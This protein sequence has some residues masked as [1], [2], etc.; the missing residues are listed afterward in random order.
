[1]RRRRAQ[2]GRARRASVRKLASARLRA[3]HR[4]SLN[5]AHPSAQRGSACGSSS[6]RHPASVRAPARTPSFAGALAKTRPARTHKSATS[7]AGP[8]ARR[9]VA[10]ATF[11]PFSPLNFRALQRAPAAQAAQAPVLNSC[12]GG[13]CVCVCVGGGGA[14]EKPRGRRTSGAQRTVVVLLLLSP[15]A[16]ICPAAASHPALVLPGRLVTLLQ[17]QQVLDRALHVLVVGLVQAR[18]HRALDVG[19]HAD[20]R[21]HA[22]HG[23]GA[24]AA[25]AAA[26]R[27]VSRS[28]VPGRPR[29]NAPCSRCCGPQLRRPFSP[30][31]PR[32]PPRSPSPPR[33]LFSSPAP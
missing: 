10:A 7:T 5:P 32:A 16:A 22:R 1:M 30:A 26:V 12:T 20:E 31:L 3:G 21:L 2:G 25:R 6:E 19:K 29:S 18:D 33:P 11:S 4:H 27:V 24:P 13:V 28:R 14:E 23:G 15:P 8:P 17:R 9:H